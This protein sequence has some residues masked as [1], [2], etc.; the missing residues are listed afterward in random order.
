MR[1]RANYHGRYITSFSAATAARNRY[2]F[3]RTV[4]DLSLSYRLSSSTQLFCDVN[5]LTNEPQKFYTYVPSQT[6]RITL[7]G[8]GVTLGVSG[9]C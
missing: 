3:A 1:V 7:N 5:N 8:T 9:R 2:R 4:T 6:Q